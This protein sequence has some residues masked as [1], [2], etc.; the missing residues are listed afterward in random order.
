V[1]GKDEQEGRRGRG[2]IIGERR[3]EGEREKG[4]NT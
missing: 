3:G 4:K 1:E 2:E